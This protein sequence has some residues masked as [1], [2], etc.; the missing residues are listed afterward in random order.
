MVLEVMR[1][2]LL[3]LAKS[4]RTGV[5]CREL[6]DDTWERLDF[7]RMTRL[8]CNLLSSSSSN[9]LACVRC[10]SGTDGEPKQTSMRATDQGVKY[11]YAFQTR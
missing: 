6:F 11:E 10:C 5:G 9:V 8:L 4:E 1:G 7:G 2:A 3:T